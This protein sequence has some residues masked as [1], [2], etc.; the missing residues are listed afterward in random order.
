MT[1]TAGLMIVEDQPLIAMMIEEMAAGLGWVVDGILYSE[2]DALTFLDANRP[3][4]ALLDTNLGLTTSLQVAAAC[5]ERKIPV[6]FTTGYKAAD[7]L[8]QC[9]N[10]PVLAKPFSTDGTSCTIIT[11]PAVEHIA[12]IHGRMPVILEESAYDASL[13]GDAKGDDAKAILLDNHLDSQLEFF[14]VGREVNN[15]RHEGA[16]TKKP[17]LN[18]L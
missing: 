15:S 1:A 18:A 4:L 7:V 8:A 17:L 14:R 5:Q 13:S 16:D 3:H 12:D 2:A 11:A 9:G 10:A 6:V